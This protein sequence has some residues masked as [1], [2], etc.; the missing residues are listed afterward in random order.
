MQTPLQINL[1]KSDV[2]E[3]LKQKGLDS[4]K[5]YILVRYQLEE[6]WLE[7]FID[8]DIKECVKRVLLVFGNENLELV[9]SVVFTIKF[10]KDISLIQKEIKE[11]KQMIE[12]DINW[13]WQWIFDTPKDP[14]EQFLKKKYNVE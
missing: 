10:Y 12:L 6:S 7:F 9:Q 5:K 1:K 8:C 3:Y 11:E 4:Y 14:I 2:I 13:D